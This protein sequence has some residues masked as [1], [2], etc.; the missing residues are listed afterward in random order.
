M[1]TLFSDKPGTLE[2]RELSPAINTSEGVVVIV[3]C[4]HPGIDRI[5]Q[6]A[7]AINPRVHLVVGGLNLVV[8]N[9]QDIEKAVTPLHDTFKVEYVAPGHCTGEPAFRG[10]RKPMEIIISTPDSAPAFR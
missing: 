1:I 4:S 5:L 6:A 7:T 9:D 8:A 3:G 2:L 10:S